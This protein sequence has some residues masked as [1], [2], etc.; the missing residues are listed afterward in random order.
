MDLTNYHKEELTMDALKAQLQALLFFLPAIIIFGI[1]FY[2]IWPEH[3][4]K[5]AWKEAV[6]DVLNGTTGTIALI[7]T[8]LVGVVIHELIHGITWSRFASKGLRSIKFGV[9]WRSATPY[10][11]CTEPLLLKNYVIGTVMPGLLMG[12][13]PLLV[14]I[15]TGNLLLFAFGLFF[16]LAA[17]GDF[18]IIN[19][20]RKKSS[21]L[22]V[23]DHPSKIGCLIYQPLHSIA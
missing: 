13:L 5:G 9:L 10:C 7:I 4:V 15:L 2:L 12:I 20:L 17:G 8:L 3:F 21:A 14:S 11:H 1:P 23:Q 6:P 18:A 22:L 19:L 16:T